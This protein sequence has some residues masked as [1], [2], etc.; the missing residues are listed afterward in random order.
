MLALA[1]QVD[2][3]DWEVDD[4]PFHAALT[5]LGIDQIGSAQAEQQQ[6]LADGD[7]AGTTALSHRP[8]EEP[9]FG[10][11]SICCVSRQK[12][13]PTGSFT[14]VMTPFETPLLAQL[15]M[16]FGDSRFRPGGAMAGRPAHV[17]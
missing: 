1:T 14:S 12:E 2:L 13:K 4:R 3:P 5:Q 9:L 16:R 11:F 7:G 8:G 6:Q 17:G 10:A 15:L